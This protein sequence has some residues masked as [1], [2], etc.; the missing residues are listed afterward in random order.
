MKTLKTIAVFAFSIFL[1]ISNVVA[2][3]A[4]HDHAPILTIEQA[5]L[6][7]AQKDLMTANRE[8]FKATLTAEQLAILDNTD[9]DKKSQKA[10]LASTFTE[11]QKSL[12]KD[13]RESVKAIR[14]EFKA[15]LTDEQRKTLRSQN[16]GKVR[17]RNG[18]GVR[19]AKRPIMK[20][21]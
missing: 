12:L 9:L 19:D 16:D 5:A 7:Q 11:A 17:D 10:A 4:K 8:A 15:S 21:N 2:Q 6:L 13:N 1:G 20:R 14:A 3:D 18:D